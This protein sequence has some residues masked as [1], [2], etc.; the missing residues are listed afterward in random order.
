MHSAQPTTHERSDWAIDDALER[1]VGHGRKS[2]AILQLGFDAKMSNE[3]NAAN[4][5]NAR[6][7]NHLKRNQATAAV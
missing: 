7:R 2:R 4:R 3:D 1:V 6:V 5:E